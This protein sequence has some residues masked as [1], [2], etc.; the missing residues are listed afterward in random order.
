MCI[1]RPRS[2]AD[3]CG[4]YWSA[5]SCKIG[6]GSVHISALDICTCWSNRQLGG[7]H[8][9]FVKTCACTST[10]LKKMNRLSSGVRMSAQQKWQGTGTGRGR[11]F[12][13]KCPIFEFFNS[14]ATT[15]TTSC[16]PRIYTK[17]IPVRPGKSP[18]YFL[19]N[20]SKEDFVTSIARHQHK[21]A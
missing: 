11:S 4:D 17:S 8:R 12:K 7:I 20:S 18:L 2:C 16:P 13:K 6:R 9:C 21:L 19:D 1:V 5:T 15:I 14:S 10:Q 3:C